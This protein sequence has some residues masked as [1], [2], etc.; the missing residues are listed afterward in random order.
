MKRRGIDLVVKNTGKPEL[1]VLDEHMAQV[2]RLP[3][4]TP[5][6]K[7]GCLRVV[8]KQPVGVLTNWYRRDYV[9]DE[10]YEEMCHNNSADLPELMQQKH[11]I[12]IS[13]VVEAVKTRAATQEERQLLQMTK[14][15]SVFE[16]HR[17]NFTQENG[18]V[19]MA[20]DLTLIA[21]YFHLEY[22]YPTRHW[23]EHHSA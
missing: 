22:S 1:V 17:V 14:P 12:T 10:M 4:G 9:D 3:V 8:N 15:G 5:A 16:I 7:R 20:S 18:D 11:G 6:I 2:F 21:Q 19:V 23:I 13:W